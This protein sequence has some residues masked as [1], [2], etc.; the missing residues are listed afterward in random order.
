MPWGAIQL[1]PGVDVQHTLSDNMAGVSQSQLIRYKENLIQCYGGWTNFVSFTIPSTVRDLHPWQDINAVQHLGVGATETLAVVTAGSYQDITPQT[2][3]TNPTP[4]FSISS[5]SNVLTIVDGSANATTFNSIF[6]NTPV[7]IGGFLLNGAYRIEAALGSTIYTV[8]LPSDSTS[9][10]AS[11]GILPRF[12][13]SSGSAQVTVTLPNHG[14]SATL[15]LLQQFIAP[16]QVGSTADGIVVQGKYQIASVI[17]STSF[18]INAT[19]LPSTTATATMNSSLAQIVYYVTLGPTPAGSGFGAGGFGSGGFGSGSASAGVAGTPI[20]ADD[21]TLCNWG[22]ILLAC[23]EDGPIYAWSPSFG[24]QNAQVVTEAPFFNGGIFISMPQ[25]ILVA[26]RSVLSTGVQDQLRVRWCNA[27]DY[28]NWTVSNQT[29]AGSFQI[30]S[31]SSIVGGR[32]CPQF[33]LIS[34]DIEVWTMTYVGGQVIFNFTKVGTGCGWISSHACGILSGNPFW[35]AN[36]NFFTLGANGVVPLPCTVWDQV[37]QNLSTTYQ[38]KVRVA[39]NS[40]FNEIAWFYPSAT[41]T[42]ENDSY[43]KVHIEGS[44]YEWDYGVMQRT[45]WT[46]VSILGM[47]IGVDATGQLYQHEDGTSIT[48]VGLPSFRTGWWAVGEGQELPFIDMIIPDFIYGLRSGAQDASLS[49]TFFGVDHPGDTPTIY[50]PYTVTAATEF[51][52]CRIRNRLLSAMIQSTAA[53]EF[54]RIGRIRFRFGQSGRR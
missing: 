19:T 14:F 49:I 21:W 39:V 33:G 15:G 36:N 51:I 37:F 29:T 32:Q 26:W 38:E 3:T 9:T 40:A 46:D 44:E 5:G 7:A 6:F 13:I 35:M 22:E 41:S 31:G 2:T 48:G 8:L 11:S 12:A 24:F 17:D 16:T 53:S 30:P 10:V 34:T 27:G 47:P 18:T 52:N 54:W 50:G 4:N 1:K 20:T 43:V 45:A 42:G 23:P 25:Q 28:T